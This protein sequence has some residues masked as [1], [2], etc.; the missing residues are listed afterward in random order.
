[1][2]QPRLTNSAIASRMSF[3]NLSNLN[4]PARFLINDC[5]GIP[6]AR[7]KG[8]AKLKLK[9]IM[10]T[11]L[12]GPMSGKV[13]ADSGV[14]VRLGLVLARVISTVT[15]EQVLGRAVEIHEQIRRTR[16]A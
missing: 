14:V 12:L 8:S 16:A 13:L 5:F 6:R 9:V 4:R 10:E 1:M 7:Y 15:A 3:S 2:T 11:M